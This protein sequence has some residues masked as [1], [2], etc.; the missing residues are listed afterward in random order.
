MFS[1][2]N[3]LQIELW[4]KAINLWSQNGVWKKQNRYKEKSKIAP[5][6]LF[7]IDIDML[8]ISNF[9]HLKKKVVFFLPLCKNRDPYVLVCG[10][11]CFFSQNI[12]KMIMNSFSKETNQL[13]CQGYQP[14]RLTS[15]IYELTYDELM[16][17]VMIQ[18]DDQ[19]RGQKCW[20]SL[21]YP[22]LICTN[23]EF[24][25]KSGQKIQ[26]E[27]V[28]MLKASKAILCAI[29]ITNTLITTLHL[30]SLCFFN[31]QWTENSPTARSFGFG[32]SIQWNLNPL[33][34]V[35]APF[36]RSTSI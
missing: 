2:K 27:T 25:S 20:Q 18:F 34:P 3:S 26:T 9:K 8:D 30:I 14:L 15:F 32:E 13:K 4:S 5:Q 19:K 29:L 24:F 35:F 10:E 31:F 11:M 23:A 6:M 21:S 28:I 7:F 17:T 22:I 33:H 36:S 12:N 1:A 16:C